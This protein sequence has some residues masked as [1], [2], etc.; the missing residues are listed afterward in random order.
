MVLAERFDVTLSAISQ[1]LRILREVG[2]VT[3]R[4]EGREHVYR[5]DAAPLQSVADWVQIYEPFWN[6]KLDALGS[7][8]DKTVNKREKSP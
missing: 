1:Q 7:Y 2:L 4:K 8:L 6:G 3:M 5:L